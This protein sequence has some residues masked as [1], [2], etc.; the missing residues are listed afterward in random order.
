MRLVE[1]CTADKV[2]YQQKFWIFR[3]FGIA[4]GCDARILAA[5]F[6]TL[7]WMLEDHCPGDFIRTLYGP[8]L[9]LVES[10]QA[11]RSGVSRPVPAPNLGVT[12]SEGDFT[13][14]FSLIC[15]DMECWIELRLCRPPSERTLLIEHRPGKVDVRVYSESEIVSKE[16]L[17]LLTYGHQI[18][19]ALELFMSFDPDY[20]G[21]RNP[22]P[23]ISHW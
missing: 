3:Y 18:Q 17:K 13:S 16:R 14:A 7:Q 2:K 8:V 23:D 11:P 4:L 21:Q 5:F 12:Y 15:W 19:R 20:W 9:D 10:L 6:H 22:L 1:F